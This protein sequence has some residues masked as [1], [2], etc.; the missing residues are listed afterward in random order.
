MPPRLEP[1]R[2]VDRLHRAGPAAAA[3]ACSRP[4]AATERLITRSWRRRPQLGGEQ[5]RADLPARRPSDAAASTGYPFE[6]ASRAGDAPSGRSGSR[7]VGSDGMIR[8]TFALL[9]LGPPPAPRPRSARGIVK[10]VI[11]GTP[12]AARPVA[13]GSTRCGPTSWRGRAATPS[14]SATSSGASAPARATLAAQAAMASA[15]S[16]RSSCASRP[17]RPRRHRD[18]AIA[19]GARRAQEV[20]DYLVLL[21]VPAGQA[22]HDQHGQGASRL[23]DAARLPSSCSSIKPRGAGSRRCSARRGPGAGLRRS[24]ARSSRRRSRRGI[25]GR[26]CSPTARRG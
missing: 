26:A 13:S 10:R 18:H 9:A 17:C 25:A 22:D 23:A 7:L 14:S 24:R 20:R 11:P 8:R 3:S 15:A 4:T 19:M 6:A 12:A 16:P 5:P 1:R 2:R 21:G